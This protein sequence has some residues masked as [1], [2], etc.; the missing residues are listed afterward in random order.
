MV[1]GFVSGVLWGGVVAA[2][3]LAVIS[4]IAPLPQAVPDT[5]PAAPQAEA[6]A[7]PLVA[8]L[9]ATPLETPAQPDTPAGDAVALAPLAETAPPAPLADGSQPAL[10]EAPLP[11]APA[12][13]PAEPALPPDVVDATAPDAP[14]APAAP[15]LPPLPQGAEPAP[16]VGATGSVVPAVTADVAP[17]VVDLPPPP[18]L[19]PEEEALI[20]PQ[21]VAPDGRAPALPRMATP[22]SGLAPVAPLP[23]APLPVVPAP[24]AAATNP[25][26]PVPGVTTDRL[27]R[28]GFDEALPEVD[29]LPEAEADTRPVTAFARPFDNPEGKPLFAILLVDTGA[30]DLDRKALAAL[31]FPV[32]FV[33]DPMA[34]GAAEA[35]AIYRAGMQEVVFAATGIPEGATAADLE[36]TFQSHAN[37][38]PEAVAVID[39]AAGGFQ[40]DRAKAGA[41]LPI[42]AD[43]GRGLVTYDRGLNAADQIARREGLPAAAVFRQLDASGESVPTIRRY[44]DRAAFKAAQEGEV[45]VIGTTAPDTVAAILEW[46]VEGRAASVALAP[47]TA[48]MTR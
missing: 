24:E 29:I 5:P 44:L 19:T 21:A 6:P 43:Q 34:G 36:Q 40:D 38:L 11:D 48:L 22:E 13:R 2:A 7:A 1:R 42:L 27:P 15:G 9:D 39:L 25:P 26:E 16:S 8:P 4:Q 14:K 31:P 47:I 33:I 10:A 32:T 45:V 41:I 20:A 35:A 46:T 28:I 3:G 23:V 37:S 18:P 17:P 30:T 12:I